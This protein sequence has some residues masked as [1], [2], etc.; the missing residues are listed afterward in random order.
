[1]T[2]KNEA[3]IKRLAEEIKGIKTAMVTTIGLDGLFRSRPMIA[4]KHEFD[5][6]LWFFSHLS[7]EKIKEVKNDNR[8]GVTFVSPV[9]NNWVAISGTAE[10]LNDK[11][12]MAKMWHSELKK[13]FPHE[14]NEPDIALLKITAHK[15]EYWEANQGVIVQLIE[16]FVEVS[17][18]SNYQV[19]KHEN[20]N[21][22]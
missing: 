15:G 13:W 2:G 3:Y 12:T 10:V 19:T 14:I 7:D 8:V 9:N 16:L 20:L 1:M 21:L 6:H 11:E 22:D 4:Q 5:G 18:N 17:Q